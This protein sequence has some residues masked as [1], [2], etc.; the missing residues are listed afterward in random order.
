MIENA[1]IGKQLSLKLRITV[2][3]LISAGIIALAVILP[4]I[5]HLV[6]GEQAGVR[7]MP[8]YLP[9]LLGGCLLGSGWG[10]CIGALSPIVSYLITS[11][12]SSPMPVLARLPFMMAELCVFALVCGAFE[13]KISRRPY[14]AFPAVISA[15][16]A[17]RASFMLLVALFGKF[18][19]F[20]T[21]MI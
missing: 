14:L 18:T 21:A 12:V 7:L 19:P 8:M 10:V 15:E 5:A 1:L 13:K 20:T 11:A 9:V 3:A 6:A 4:Q 17:G 2:K 16:I